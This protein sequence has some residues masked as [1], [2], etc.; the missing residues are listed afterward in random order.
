MCDIMWFSSNTIALLIYWNFLSCNWAIASK[1]HNDSIC[2]FW[3]SC[4]ICHAFLYTLLYVVFR[5]L[6]IGSGYHQW[7]S[8]SVAW[9]CLCKQPTG[10]SPFSD[11]CYLLSKQ[12]HVL[13]HDVH[14]CW[15][16]FPNLWKKVLKCWKFYWVVY[17]R[18]YNHCNFYMYVWVETSCHHT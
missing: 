17:S 11:C 1:V 2:V 6:M 10:I 16:T 18:D 15:E 13:H 14:A 9:Y 12:A 8:P 5:V 4:T 3:V 7:L